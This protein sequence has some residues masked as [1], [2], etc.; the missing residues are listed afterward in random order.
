MI[1]VEASLAEML[2]ARAGTVDPDDRLAELLSRHPAT[3][4]AQV[5]ELRP[6]Y[7]LEPPSRPWRRLVAAAA[8]ALVAVGAAG[9]WVA[10]SLGNG[11]VA[12]AR[13]ETPPVPLGTLAPVA[14]PDGSF[15][16]SDRVDQYGDENSMMRFTSTVRVMDV[17]PFGDGY[18]AVGT[19]ELG[20]RH[21]AAIWRS[22]D[23]TR[24][25]PIASE[26]LAPAPVD[27]ARNSYGFELWEV[28]AGGARAVAAGISTVDGRRTLSVWVSDDGDHWE[29][30]DL[31]PL[32]PSA[33]S[34]ITGMEVTADGF[35]AVG[36]DNTDPDTGDAN[37]SFA[38]RSVDGLAWEPVGVPVFDEPGTFV[39]GL[40]SVGD[41]LV[42]YGSVGGHHGTAAAWYSDDGGTSWAVAAVPESHALP[43]SYAID[44]AAAGDGVALVG[45]DHD[46]GPVAGS[47]HETGVV[48]PG[49][50]AAFVWFGDGSA[51][52]SV[53]T[54]AVNSSQAVWPWAVTDGPA[55]FVL[56][57]ARVDATGI[58]TDLWSWTAATGF[59]A[60]PA[61]ASTLNE[62]QSLAA[63]P[64]GYLV[65]TREHP[66][67]SG[68]PFDP[69]TDGD[70]TLLW[71]LP[72][73]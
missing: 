5:V 57:T 53:D 66:M 15:V 50:R 40:T 69:P 73:T 72:T 54:A 44:G 35:V 36:I 64:D 32:T 49:H 30:V 60:V 63:V 48:T 45:S 26:A 12:L 58:V 70:D 20:A 3:E 1:D 56:A 25:S 43:S 62:V 4:P 23:G 24:W 59:A 46:N 34:S 16:A 47:N 33:W 55:G 39:N 7:Y 8:A 18:L 51:F 52:S 14:D 11:S 38:I 68:D 17:T 67:I 41:R 22:P 19:S 21:D 9:M 2:T 29:W 28:A 10:T 31:A 61:G 13:L 42:A 65:A 71:V 37:R 6:R 27:G